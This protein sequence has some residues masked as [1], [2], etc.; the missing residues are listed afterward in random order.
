MRT[1]VSAL[2]QDITLTTDSG[3]VVSRLRIN[4]D[5]DDK[6]VKILLKNPFE[7]F[8]VKNFLSIFFCVSRLSS[9]CLVFRYMFLYFKTFLV[10][11][12]ILQYF[13][14]PKVSAGSA[15]KEN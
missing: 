6:R 12:S 7:N 11:V 5:R 8:P 4:C 15:R 10:C 2:S 1:P 3:L 14:Q 13:L 9:Y